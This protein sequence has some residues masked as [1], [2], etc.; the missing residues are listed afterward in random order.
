MSLSPVSLERQLKLYKGL[1]EVSA[2]I[3]AITESSELLPAILEVARRVMEVEAASLFL[4][5]GDGELELTYA[6]GGIMAGTSA[7]EARIVVPRGRGIAGWVLEHGE[8]LLVPDAYADP[9]FFKDTDRQTGFRTRSILCAPMQRKGKEIGVLQVLNPIGREAFDEDDL[10]AFRAYGDLAATAIDKL[11]TIERQQEQQR[12]AQE[13]AFAREIQAS[14][15]PQSLP[16]LSH[17][18][19]AATYRPALNVGGDFYDVIESGPDEIYFV[20]GDVSGKGMPA[21]LLMAQALSILRLIVKPGISPVAAMARWNAMI[22]GHTIRGMFITAMLGRL[23][24]STRE[25]ELCSAGHCHPFTTA[26][27]GVKEIKIPGS[28]P[29]GLLPELPSRSHTLTL[30]QNEWLVLYTDGLVESFNR[31]DVPLDGVGVQRLLSREFASATD[32]VDGLNRGE[33]NHRQG[34]EPHDDLTILV[35]GFQ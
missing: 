12:V 23:V 24:L 32:V 35:F 20:V 25:V 13:F 10:A 5:N 9:R 14:F 16:S 7:P 21:A 27:S 33:I 6:S 26:Q 28:P 17:V 34:A 2:L 30:A 15:L 29:L 19:F 1:V 22:S 31:E 8:A 4:V 3:N 11:R 18:H